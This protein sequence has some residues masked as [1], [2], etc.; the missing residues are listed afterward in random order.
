MKWIRQ[1]L[2]PCF[3]SL[4][5]VAGCAEDVAPP[6]LLR[7]SDAKGGT[8][9]PKRAD[10]IPTPDPDP[11]PSSSTPAGTPQDGTPILSAIAPDA[12]TIGTAPQGLDVTITGTRFATGAQAE[13]AGAPVATTVISATQLSVR[14]PAD[15]IAASGVLRVLVFAKPGAPSNPLSFTVANPSSVVISQ[16]TPAV[17]TIGA[18]G[19]I[20]LSVTGSGFVPSSLVKFNGSALAT[21]FTS[22]TQLSAAIPADAFL[23]AGK[24]GV[25]VSSSGDIVSLP[26]GFEVRNP[27]PQANALTPRVATAGS[28]ALAVT[29]DGAGFTKGSEVLASGS[30][31]ATTFISAT[32]LRAAL[33]A[34]LLTT[35]RT[36]SL[37]VQ[38]PGPGGGTS[39]AQTFTVQAAAGTGA[40]SSSGGAGGASCLYSCAE[41]NYAP[42]ECYQGWYCIPTGTYAGCLGQ[43]ACN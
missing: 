3:F 27:T 25:T 41:Y 15:R 26:V 39:V 31:L 30:P 29:I 11:A 33:P 8:K 7:N 10:P 40:G 37:I 36:L 21:T 12:V 43:T 35:A 14:I 42:G 4:G 20:T 6:P 16:L 32:R 9:P 5:V 24:Y 18:T 17:A 2:L 1:L 19:P 38:S 22:A 28:A 13:L 34:A 23:D